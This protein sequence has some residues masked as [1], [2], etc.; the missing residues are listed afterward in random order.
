[1]SWPILDLQHPVHEDWKPRLHPHIL[2]EIARGFHLLG[3]R[4]ALRRWYYTLSQAS[5]RAG[6]NPEQ[7]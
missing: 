4:G 3:G 6:V 1:M 2:S 7:R 5:P